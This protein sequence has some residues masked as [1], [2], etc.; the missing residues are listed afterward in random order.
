MSKN[1]MFVQHSHETSIGWF[2]VNIKNFNLELTKAY[3]DAKKS[4]GW[5]NPDNGYLDCSGVTMEK[6]PCVVD[7]V[8]DVCVG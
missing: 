6:L 4:R 1:V 3:A 5:V 7:E 2:V 8:I